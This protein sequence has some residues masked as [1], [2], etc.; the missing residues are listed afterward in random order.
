MAHAM[1]ALDLLKL[2]GQ[3]VEKPG[4]EPVA[5][6]NIQEKLN[7][8]PTSNELSTSEYDSTPQAH[9]SQKYSKR[10][11]Y[12]RKSKFNQM[13]GTTYH[14]KTVPTEAAS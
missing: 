12:Y 11:P 6:R 14:E 7:L 1:T 2:E 5:Q 4:P 10:Q 13:T 8:P 9:M 3:D